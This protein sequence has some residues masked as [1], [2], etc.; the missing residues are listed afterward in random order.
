MLK[1][2]QLILLSVVFVLS[3]LVWYAVTNKDQ[4][5][6]EHLTSAP[7]SVESLEKELKKTQTEL[8][9]L[10]KEFHDLKDQAGAQAQEAA[11]AKASL[12][13]IH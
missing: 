4:L 5:I 11:A 3:F 8:K 7:P 12:A 9:S 1:R 6:R 13:A 2:K 10:S